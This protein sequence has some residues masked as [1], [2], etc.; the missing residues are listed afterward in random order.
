MGSAETVSVKWFF[1]VFHIEYA[2]KLLRNRMIS[3][4]SAFCTDSIYHK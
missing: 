2:N 4:V 1:A 3:L